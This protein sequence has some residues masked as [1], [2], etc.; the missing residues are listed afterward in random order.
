MIISNLFV[1]ECSLFSEHCGYIGTLGKR[2]ILYVTVWESAG[3]EWRCGSVGCVGLLRV[4]C[5]VLYC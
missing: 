1:L 2:S 4:L 3:A 5:S